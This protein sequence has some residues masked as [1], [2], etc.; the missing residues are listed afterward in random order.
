MT[1]QHNNRGRGDPPTAFLRHFFRLSGRP[2]TSRQQARI[3]DLQRKLALRAGDS[4]FIIISILELYLGEIETACS[5]VRQS[6]RRTTLKACT[7]AVMS[8]AVMS[9]P[10]YLLQPQTR[11]ALGWTQYAGTEQAP[12]PFRVYMRASLDQLSDQDLAKL[13]TS[14]DALVILQRL[15][16]AT[17]MELGNIAKYLQSHGAPEAR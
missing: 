6:A 12:S 15:P 4:I 14:S 5:E 1:D 10:L 11:S 17:N 2:P 3:V 9:A 8:A 7:I 13:A 16:Q